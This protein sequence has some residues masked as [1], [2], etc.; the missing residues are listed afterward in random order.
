MRGGLAHYLYSQNANKIPVV[1]ETNVSKFPVS[2]GFLSKL[3]IYEATT[4]TKMDRY[5]KDNFGNK[6]MEENE[7]AEANKFHAHIPSST[8]DN[9]DGDD[10]IER[11]GDDSNYYQR[12]EAV[13]TSY[14]RDCN[15]NM[16]RLIL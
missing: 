14:S 16:D 10:E 8:H 9:G 12:N 5:L 1:V 11:I 3:A 15:V 6:N 7:A 4:H 2:E 13:N